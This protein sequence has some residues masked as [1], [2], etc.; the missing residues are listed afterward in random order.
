MNEFK[1]FTLEVSCETHIVNS[2]PLAHEIP[3]VFEYECTMCVI[4]VKTQERQAT[5]F[6]SF[7]SYALY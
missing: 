3:F 7:Y 1:M 6:M 5:Y 4:Q 2:F